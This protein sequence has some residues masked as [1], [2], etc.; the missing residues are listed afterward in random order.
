MHFWV[1]SKICIDL[2]INICKI[3]VGYISMSE[4]NG[5]GVHTLAS[6]DTLKSIDTNLYSHKL[7]TSIVVVPY[8]HQHLLFQYVLTFRTYVMNMKWF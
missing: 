5:Y 2:L 7:R 6:V 8:L 3:S 1:V 4:I